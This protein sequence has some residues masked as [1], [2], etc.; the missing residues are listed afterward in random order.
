MKKH[1]VYLAKCKD[2]T[3]YAGYTIDLKERES[4]HNAGEGAKYTKYR[5]PVKIVYSEKFKTV[6]QAMKREAEIKK[7][8][9]KEKENLIKPS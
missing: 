5:R 3:L 9:R 2:G 7:L 8:S 4:K 6:G 1:Y